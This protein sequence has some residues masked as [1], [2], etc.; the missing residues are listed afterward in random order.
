MDSC[1]GVEQDL[2]KALSK[3][4]S[5]NDNSSKLLQNIIDQVEEI[6]QEITKREYFVVTL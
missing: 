4:K 2:D 5:L 3:F 6:R 1:L